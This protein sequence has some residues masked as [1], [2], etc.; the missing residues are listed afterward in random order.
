MRQLLMVPLVILLTMIGTSVLFLAAVVV[1]K[2]TTRAWRRIEQRRGRQ[3][4]K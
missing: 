3:S 1:A 2:E 4:S